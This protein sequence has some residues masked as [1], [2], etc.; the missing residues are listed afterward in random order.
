MNGHEVPR[1]KELVRDLRRERA[2]IARELLAR[3][4]DRHRGAMLERVERAILKE[5]IERGCRC[6]PEDVDRRPRQLLHAIDESRGVE[7]RGIRQ[8]PVDDVKCGAAIGEHPLPQLAEQNGRIE[9]RRGVGRG[10]GERRRVGDL[11]ERGRAL[12]TSRNVGQV[13]KEI[14]GVDERTRFAHEGPPGVACRTSFR[15]HVHAVAE[16]TMSTRHRHLPECAVDSRYGSVAIV[17]RT[18]DVKRVEI[19]PVLRV[20]LRMNLHRQPERGRG[21]LEMHRDVDEGRPIFHRA[22]LRSRC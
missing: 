13:Q 12:P 11:R 6:A 22:R 19:A 8:R 7:H 21:I 4:A 5:E 15:L 18:L 1:V 3:Q 14:G 20:V 10:E 9:Q 16:H 17:G 2:P